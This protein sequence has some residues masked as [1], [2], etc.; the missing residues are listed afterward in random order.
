MKP[1]EYDLALHLRDQVIGDADGHGR[2]NSLV[3]RHHP[4]GNYPS[5]LVTVHQNGA[6]HLV[7]HETLDFLLIGKHWREFRTAEQAHLFAQA[8]AN[9]KPLIASLF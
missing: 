7:M 1:F 9:A 5:S 4:F 3:V 6:A 8:Q 2:L